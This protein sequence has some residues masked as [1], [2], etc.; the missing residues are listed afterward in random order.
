M[1]WMY[2][3]YALIILSLLTLI[4]YPKWQPRY[5]SYVT[6][7]RVEKN[8][9]P[10]QIRLQTEELMMFSRLTRDLGQSPRVDVLYI[11]AGVLEVSIS[12]VA[13]KLP[14]FMELIRKQ[15]GVPTVVAANHEEAAALDDALSGVKEGQDGRWYRDQ[16]T[17]ETARIA[18]R[19]IARAYQHQD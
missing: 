2:V 11:D 6:I 18:N 9:T 17:I 16:A 14:P 12:S 19:I 5:S 15:L 8:F 3:T 7:R 10:K 1:V 4:T 13:V